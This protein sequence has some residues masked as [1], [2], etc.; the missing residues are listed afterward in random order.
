MILNL[1]KKFLYCWDVL[2]TFIDNTQLKYYYRIKEKLEGVSDIRERLSESGA[3]SQN[4]ED[5]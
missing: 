4:W 5:L 1:T 2:F 3:Y